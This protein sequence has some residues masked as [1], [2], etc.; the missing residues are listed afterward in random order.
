MQNNKTLQDIGKK[1]KPMRYSEKELSLIKNTFTDV[2]FIISIRNFLLQGEQT[3]SELRMIKSV[4]GTPETFNILKKAVNP[5][6]DKSAN[7]FQSVDLFS[8]MDV[9]PVPVEHAVNLI[10]GKAVAK[11]YLDER[12]DVLNGK[13]VTGGIVFDDL[14]KPLGKL[15]KAE[16]FANFVARNFL[17]SHIDSQLF[18]SLM[19]IAGT[20]EETVE[21]QAARLMQDSSK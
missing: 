8:S 21:E 3:E 11:K 18:G 6:L 14:V 17:L 4:F 15:K 2:A 12:F 20:K 19:V 5:D 7:P 10:A 9:Q 16:T 1:L 13:T